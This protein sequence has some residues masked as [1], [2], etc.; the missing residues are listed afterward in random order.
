MHL[1]KIVK[2]GFE[3][4]LLHKSDLVIKFTTCAFNMYQLL[5]MEW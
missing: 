4:T 2:N 5:I 1:L 3:I